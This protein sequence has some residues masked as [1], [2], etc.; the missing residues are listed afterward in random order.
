M[1]IFIIID[2]NGIIQLPDVISGILGL[3]FERRESANM[4]GQYF[5]FN[6]V[7][8]D[9]RLIDHGRDKAIICEFINIPLPDEYSA[10]KTVM[11]SIATEL[12]KS[13]LNCRILEE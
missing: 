10:Y 8:A 7:F 9:I 13:G 2:N 12:N 3:R 4:G 5:R 11:N 6:S 1:T